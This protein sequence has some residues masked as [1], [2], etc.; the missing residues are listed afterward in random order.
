MD[1]SS[2]PYDIRRRVFAFACSVIKAYPRVRLDTA[3]HKVWAQLIASAT[4]AGAHLEEAAAGGSRAHFLALNR[5]A[6][7]EMR[8]SDYWLRI[9]ITTELQDFRKATPLQNE[10]REL[11]AILSTIVRRT[12]ENNNKTTGKS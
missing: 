9:L 7:R 8:E 4:S 6:L 11:V 2:K 10:S 12:Y 3:S 5:G 1:S